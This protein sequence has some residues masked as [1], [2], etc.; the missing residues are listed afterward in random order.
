M[1]YQK[2][3]ER[4]VTFAPP[5]LAAH[6]KDVRH[7]IG[8]TVAVVDVFTWFDIE[9][10][11]LSVRVLVANDQ[12]CR[13]RQRGVSSV[14]S[15]ARGGHVCDTGGDGIAGTVVGNAWHGHLVAWLPA[16][17]DIIDLTLGA[18][19]RPAKDIRLPAVGVFPFQPPGGDYTINRVHLEYIAQPEVVSWRL[20]PDYHDETRRAI[21]REPLLRAIRKGRC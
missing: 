14:S 5:I 19:S 15:I 1:T 6:T 3:L 17:G 12:Y 8:A 13:D 2:I 7:C 18:F 11:P 21:I 10:E 4:L 20:S 16:H 9:A